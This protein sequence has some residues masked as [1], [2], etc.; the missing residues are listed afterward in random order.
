MAILLYIFLIIAICFVLGR[1]ILSFQ[2]KRDVKL[3]FAQSRIISDK[4]FH[5]E[6]LTGLPEPVQRYFNLIL[7]NGQPYISY[8]RMT[9]DG[10]F[11]TGIDKA[12]VNIEGEQ[13]ATTERPGF[14]WKGTTSMFTARDMYLSHKGRLVV[15][16]FSVFNIL[17]AHGENYNQGELLR[18][19]GESV[20]YPTNLLQSEK[21]VW[22]SISSNSARLTFNY[23]GLSLFFVVTFNDVGEIIQLETKR[24][25]DKKGLQTWVIKL[26]EYE[27]K[28]GILIPTKFEVLWRLKEGDL[29][30][31]RFKLKEIE[32]DKSEIF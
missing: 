3:L 6:Q 7:K 14:I 28:N 22:S 25:M 5:P 27:N 1:T 11:K 32:Y 29:S 17:D 2:F 8:V 23:N 31:A 12:W 24:Y 15:S 19:L 26:A 18:W 4:Q 16:L 21:L 10:Q 13:Y 9:H 20:L 30:Y